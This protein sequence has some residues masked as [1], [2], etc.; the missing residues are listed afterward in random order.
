MDLISLRDTVP[1]DKVVRLRGGWGP[2]RKRYAGE[3]LLRLTY[4]AYVDD[5]EEDIK[6]VE[7]LPSPSAPASGADGITDTLPLLNE[8]IDKVVETVRMENPKMIQALSLNAKVNSDS[9]DNDSTM[10]SEGFGPRDAGSEGQP[11]EKDKIL[12][13]AQAEDADRLSGSK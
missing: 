5:E 6:R 2:F 1:V 8:V 12:V 11:T 13:S 4:T 3:V 10:I 7:P 9:Q